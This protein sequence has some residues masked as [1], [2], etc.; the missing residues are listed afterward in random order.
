MGRDAGADLHRGSSVAPRVVILAASPFAVRNVAHSGICS[1]LADAG[2]RL[3]ILTPRNL[4]W[5][6]D[7]ALPQGCIHEFLM[8]APAVRSERGLSA[9]RALLRRSFA[10]RH[11]VTTQ[12][13]LERWRGANGAPSSPLRSAALDALAV[14]GSADPCY[15]WQARYLTYRTRRALQLDGVNDQLRAI[16]PVLLVST[17]CVAQ[18]ELPYILGAPTLGIPMFGCILSF[19]NLTSRGLLPEFDQYA[20]WNARMRDQVLRFYPHRSAS[21]VHVTGTPQFDF[22]VRPDH[23]WPRS[24]ALA[25]LGLGGADRYVLLGANHQEFTPTEPALVIEMARRFGQV[26]TLRDHRIVVRPHPYDDRARWTGIAERHR[27]IVL[28]WPG[29]A[30]GPRAGDQELLVNTLAHADVCLNTASTM[31]LDALAVGTPVVCIGF[32]WREG[33]GEDPGCRVLH[34]SDHYRPI[35]ESGGVRLA[36]GMD[37]LI[38]EVTAYVGDRTRDADGRTRLVAEECGQMDGEGASRMAGVIARTAHELESLKT[39]AVA[40]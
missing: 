6:T 37:Q 15:R 12:R 25:R 2:L 4:P 21:T 29:D 22:H 3:W 17:A 7:V 14:P 34:F 5:P 1:L 36:E 38:A 28:S 13:L 30:D 16:D 39:V 33:R 27:R 20:V 19:D 40:R 26:A 8:P 32:G 31:T 11:G 18:G 23:R 24:Q 35:I 10:R 9:Q